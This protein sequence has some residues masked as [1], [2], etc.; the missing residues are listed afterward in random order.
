MDKL[1]LSKAEAG[2]ILGLSLSTIDRL[3]SAGRIAIRRFGRRVLICRSEIE[4]LA[5]PSASDDRIANSDPESRRMPSS[6]V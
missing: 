3:I 5:N 2:R 4:K 6:K 1:M